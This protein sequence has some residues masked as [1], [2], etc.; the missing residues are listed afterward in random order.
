MASGRQGAETV[1]LSY[2]PTD[3]W[4]AS[5]LDSESYRAYL[6]RTREG[7]VDIGDEYEEFVNCGCGKTRDVTLR[8]EAIDGMSVVTRE[9]RFVFEP[10]DG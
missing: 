7:S 6:R 4:T 10:S 8:V 3:D 2:N 1:V 5:A 9:T